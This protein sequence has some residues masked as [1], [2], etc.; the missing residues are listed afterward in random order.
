[1]SYIIFMY[2]NMLQEL[3]NEFRLVRARFAVRWTLAAPSLQPC[4]AFIAELSICLHFPAAVGGMV[5]FMPLFITALVAARMDGFGPAIHQVMRRLRLSRMT[6]ADWLWALIAAVAILVLTVAVMAGANALL[7]L[8][9]LPPLQT[10]P[11][12]LHFDPLV[13]RE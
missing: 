2:K 3:Q 4:P 13:G 12:F 8:A 7:T 10:T 5:V 6:A 1:M 9:G 11:P